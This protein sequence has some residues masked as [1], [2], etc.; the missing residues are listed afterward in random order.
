MQWQ[1]IQLLY[2]LEQRSSQGTSRVR[3]SWPRSKLRLSPTLV[4]PHKHATCCHAQPG[5][6]LF[7]TPVQ[8]SPQHLLLSGWL[9][10]NVQ[11]NIRTTL[12]D[13]GH[14]CIYSTT[15]ILSITNCI[16]LSTLLQFSRAGWLFSISSV[17]YSRYLVFVRNSLCWASQGSGHGCNSPY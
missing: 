15:H 2:I 10:T 12:H 16:L 11:A 17:L 13:T 4:S 9:L 14:T 7:I 1:G 5:I 8:V 6:K 3:P